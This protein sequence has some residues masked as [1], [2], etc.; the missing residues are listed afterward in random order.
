MP[1]RKACDSCHTKK[2]QCDRAEPRCEWCTHRDLQCTYLRKTIHTYNTDVTH[3]RTESRLARLEALLATGKVGSSC[4][5]QKVDGFQHKPN[6]K[7][8]TLRYEPTE[9]EKLTTK[10]WKQGIF[11]GSLHFA[12]CNLGEVSSVVGIPVFS[13]EGLQWIE[14]RTGSSNLFKAV[15]RRPSRDETRSDRI[16]ARREAS[17]SLPLKSTVLSCFA[18]FRSS[19]LRRIFPVV[20]PQEFE[21]AIHHAYEASDGNGSAF[22]L[23]AQTCVFAFLS[24]FSLLEHESAQ[25]DFSEAEAFAYEAQKSLVHILVDPTL[26]GLEAALMLCIYYDFSGNIQTSS[27]FHSMAVRCV[28]S[29]GAQLNTKSLAVGLQNHIRELFWLSYFFDKHISMRRGQ[30]S[31]INDLECD[32]GLDEYHG[33]ASMGDT[34]ESLYPSDLRLTIIK[35][36]VSTTLYSPSALKKSDSELFR[37]IRDLDDQLEQWRLSVP[38]FARPRLSVVNFGSAVDIVQHDF[39]MLV[40]FIHLEYLYLVSAIHTACGR[41]E[42]WSHDTDHP[43]AISS[44]LT[45]SVHASRSTLH[46]LESASKHV[47]RESFW[48]IIFYPVWATLTIFCNILHDP[49]N[50]LALSDMEMLGSIPRLIEQMRTRDLSPDEIN[51]LAMLDAFIQELLRLARC[52]V[53][54]SNDTREL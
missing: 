7:P 29:L 15:Y 3:A 41:C 6:P 18:V 51:Q 19:P 17:T 10:P 54:Q 48:L 1:R 40:I 13:D 39:G 11:Y 16:L 34:A 5:L 37:D 2:I 52:A 31:S 9:T 42:T 53:L 25:I 26:E 22:S 44:S 32:L 12:G 35:S 8:Q 20:D 46:Y 21:A 23:G 24:I 50:E 33:L 28:Y 45:L 27:V 14:K 43:E 4:S 47:H 38:E 36:K 49:R 30:P